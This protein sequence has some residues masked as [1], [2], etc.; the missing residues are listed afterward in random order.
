MLA[1]KSLLGVRITVALAF[2]FARATVNI[3]V[4]DLSIVVASPNV[5][6]DRIILFNTLPFVPILV[7]PLTSRTADGDGVPIPTLPLPSILMCPLLAESVPPVIN[8]NDLAGVL[9]PIK[10]FSPWLYK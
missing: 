6:V 9:A 10:K 4:V 5:T 7:V 3:L 8:I 2:E 1:G